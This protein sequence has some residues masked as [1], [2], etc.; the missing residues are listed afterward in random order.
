MNTCV[1]LIL[2]IMF[3]STWVS[4][5]SM[6]ILAFS[7]HPDDAELGT[8]GFLLEMRARGYST[9]II[10]LTEGELSSTASREIRLEESKQASRLLD[11]EVRENLKLGD[12]KLTDHYQA[13]LKLAEVIREYAP[14]LV[15]APYHE[16]RHP[17]HSAC[18]VLVKHAL[19]YAR[20]EKLGT[21]HYVT[22]LF[23]YL[24]NQPFSPSFIVDITPSFEKKMEVLS[25]YQSQFSSNLP[26]LRDY[27]PQVRIK[28]AYYGSLIN[29]GYG[30]PFLAEGFLKVSDPLNI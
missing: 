15:L 6:D 21:P 14:T 1:K 13:R 4:E 26:F 28:A 5:M 25:C 7:P 11:L 30:E 24:L 8:G 29:T 19:V 27:L 18:S 3:S 16:D 20:L 17:D 22:H 23:Y 9:G 10:D 12:G 2:A